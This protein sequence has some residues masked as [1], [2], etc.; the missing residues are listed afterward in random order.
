MAG[1]TNTAT[2]G[3]EHFHNE[4][5]CARISSEAGYIENPRSLFSRLYFYHKVLNV[6]KNHQNTISK[7][8]NLTMHLHIFDFKKIIIVMMNK[9]LASGDKSLN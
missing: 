2:E 6:P 3:R 9:F 1:P 4:G 8:T 5:A 7:Y